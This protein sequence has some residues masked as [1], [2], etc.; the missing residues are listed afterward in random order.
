MNLLQQAFEAFDRYNAQDPNQEVMEGKSYP[1]EVLYGQRMTERLNQ[2]APDA[3]QHVQ[4]A[5]RCQHIGRWEI[6]RK[7]FPMDRKGYLQWRTAEKLHQS[8]I[9]ESILHELRFDLPTIEK[10]KNLLMKKELSTNADTQL[11]EDVICLVFIEHY[12]EEFASQHEDEKV[13][14]ILFKTMRKMTPR[15]LTEAG[16]IDV[17]DKL[18]GLIGEAAGKL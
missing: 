3:P 4:L 14:D 11:L 12:L 18:K 9:A 2:Y 15:G 6:A 1:K 17:S 13:V 7:S 8:S 5:A 10:V 16:K